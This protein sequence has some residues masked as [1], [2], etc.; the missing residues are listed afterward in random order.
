[1]F[2][3]AETAVPPCAPLLCPTVKAALSA[4]SQAV[5]KVAS[6]SQH[7]RQHAS[8]GNAVPKQSVHN[9]TRV[10]DHNVY[11]HVESCCANL[12]VNHVEPC[13]AGFKQPS[14]Q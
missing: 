3:Y 4:T 2:F 7:S 11:A 12:G 6:L 1:M 14:H 10:V 5:L 9:R 13:C 8:G